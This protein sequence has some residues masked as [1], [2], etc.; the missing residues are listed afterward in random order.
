MF[1][2]SLITDNNK[3]MSNVCELKRALGNNVLCGAV[4]DV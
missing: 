1:Y 2:D 4:G 3:V